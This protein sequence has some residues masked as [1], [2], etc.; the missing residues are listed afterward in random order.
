MSD[1]LHDLIYDWN[2]GSE[3]AAR[4]SGKKIQF[5]DQTLRDRLQSPSVTDPSIDEKIRILHYMHAGGT[6]RADIGVP[7]AGPD[8]GRALERLAREIVDNKLSVY[9]SAAG[10]THENDVQ[11][12]IDI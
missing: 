2:A 7:G 11:P 9:P 12:I 5:D 1:S 6:A 10:R 4:P 8:V 3:R